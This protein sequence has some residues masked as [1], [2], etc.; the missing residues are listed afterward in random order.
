MIFDRPEDVSILPGM[1][2]RVRANVAREAGI[3]IPL[4]AAQSNAGLEAFVWKVDPD[5]MTVSPQ[6]VELGAV[7]GALVD[8]ESGLKKGDIIATSGLRFLEA[9]MQVRRY[10]D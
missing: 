5:S 4:S 1:T 9:G 6:P 10:G 7:H 8:I 3:S 2:A